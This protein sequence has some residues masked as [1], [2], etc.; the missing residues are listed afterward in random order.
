LSHIDLHIHTCES[1]GKYTPEEIVARAALAGLKVMSICDHDTTKGVATALEAAKNFPELTVIPGVEISTDVPSGEVHILGYFIDYDGNELCTILKSMQSSRVERA[2]KMIAKL[3]KLGIRIDWPRVREIAGD[4]TV[5][6]PHIARAML[7]KGYIS[8]IKDAFVRYIGRGG[9]AY[10]EW[11]KMTPARAVALVVRSHGLPVLA[12]PLT[13][14]APEALVGELVPA[15]LAGIE[16][17]YDDNSAEQIEW[18]VNLARRNRLLV[19]GGS[20]YHG[21]DEA[22]ETPVGGAPVPDWV[23]EKLFA[24]AKERDITV[25]V[26]KQ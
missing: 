17:F 1:D 7:E 13:V 22:A 4:G 11:E 16:A 12:H 5:G 3:T 19:T 2:H 26:A 21:L 18:V 8:S 15:G 23:A 20:D 6:R 9:P 24:L 14:T 10:V 25:S